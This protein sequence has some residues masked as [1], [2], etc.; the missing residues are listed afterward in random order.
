[1]G[2][3]ES[4]PPGTGG[5]P[6]SGRRRR[7][8]APLGLGAQGREGEQE[9]DRAPGKAAVAVLPSVVRVS[10]VPRA[11]PRCAS[12]KLGSERRRWVFSASWA[13]TAGFYWPDGP[14]LHI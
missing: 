2:C 11:A 6:S 4:G 9:E 3:P 5:W 1:M 12:R 8:A 14:Y 13:A 10:T 7:G